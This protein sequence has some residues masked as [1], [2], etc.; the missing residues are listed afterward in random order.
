MT[1]TKRN[2]KIANTETEFIYGVETGSPYEIPASVHNILVRNNLIHFD[3]KRWLF[4][5]SSLELIREQLPKK[6]VAERTFKLWVTV[7]EH[8]IYD[9][10]SDDYKDVEDDTASAGQFG[11]IEEAERQ[12][13]LIHETFGKE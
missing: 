8:I 12:M 6:K 9:D 5:K 3:G 13:E 1:N 11:T 4:F 2:I 10:G 7:E